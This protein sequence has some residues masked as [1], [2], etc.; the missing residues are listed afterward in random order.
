MLIAA[1][2]D[3]P[4]NAFAGKTLDAVY[5]GFTDTE[6]ERIKGAIRIGYAEGQTNQQ[7]MNRVRGTSAAKWNDGTLAQVKRS[8]E[9]LVRT[10]VQHTANSVRQ[11]LWA[12]NDDIVKKVEWLS[13]L[14][15]RTSQQCAS[16]DGTKWPIDKGPRPP[17]HPRCRSTTVA[18][19][20]GK[21]QKLI[22][23]AKRPAR[24]PKTGKASRISASTSYYDWMKR[25]PASVQDS[26][27]G[28]ARGKLLRNGGLS[29]ERFAELQLNRNFQP[30][31]LA[32]M[33]K[34][35]PVAFEKAGP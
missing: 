29:S 4:V 25:Q 13:T 9:T 28:P 26:V 10:S 27:I 20:D 33:R 24:D 14:D 12:A 5:K 8:V 7:I 11:E 1:T 22:D 23:S 3:K 15:R 35:D 31:T 19:L 16:L 17:I 34:I 2:F 21:Y 32:E 6:A 30:I 18:V